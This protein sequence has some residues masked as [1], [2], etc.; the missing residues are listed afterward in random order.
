MA[1]LLMSGATVAQVR[2]SASGPDPM[3]Q[4]VSYADGQ[5][6]VLEASPGF[7][8]T[9]ELGDGEQIKSA[10]AG[11]AASWQVA[12]PDRAS[13][14][15]IRP[16]PGA[17]PTNLTVV[18]N[19]HSYYFLLIPR[20]AMTAANA[21]SVR[22]SYPQAVA[23]ALPVEAKPK[24]EPGSYKLSGSRPILP[25][26]IWDDGQKTYLNWPDGVEA[27]AVFAIDAAGQESLVNS[28]W[29]D[30][31]FV[32]DAVYSRLLFRLDRLTATAER[33]ASRS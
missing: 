18:S 24:R 21:L 22:F 8:L 7:Q 6:V 15:F 2:P 13:Q 30:G 16:N 23:A 12:A 9:V 33:K 19:R 17:Q 11:D 27:P 3:H 1:L 5:T 31:R 28:H 10:V 20:A 14:F 26:Q 25:S 4:S 32:I 29:R